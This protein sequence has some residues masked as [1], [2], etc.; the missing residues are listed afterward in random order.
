MVRR[1]DKLMWFRVPT[2]ITDS[3][4]DAVLLKSGAIADT[5]EDR[6]FVAAGKTFFRDHQK[7]LLGVHREVAQALDLSKFVPRHA[8]NHSFLLYKSGPGPATRCHQ[9]RPYWLDIEP[10]CTMFTVWV[11]LED[12]TENMGALTLNPANEVD[13]ETFF[14][15]YKS[16]TLLDHRDDQ[17]GGGGFSI[18]LPD[19]VAAQFAAD[20]VPQPMKRGDIVVFD[21][22][23]PHAS[24]DNAADTTRLAMKLVYGDPD[25]MAS[26]LIGPEKLQSGGLANKFKRL[27]GN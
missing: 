3:A 12:V 20:F 22:F 14:S 6:H 18:T 21:A 7:L 25:S 1:E 13:L 26:Y 9:D 4:I 8:I 10:D 5:Q 11:A 16:G 17:Y 2:A 27:L 24:T 15:G 23:E 19:D